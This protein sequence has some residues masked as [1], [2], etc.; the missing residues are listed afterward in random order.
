MASHL[1]ILSLVGQILSGEKMPGNPANEEYETG[2][3]HVYYLRWPTSSAGEAFYAESL[4]R[5]TRTWLA[6]NSQA[7]RTRPERFSGP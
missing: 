2:E 7:P 3:R 1:R 6:S 5:V 4:A